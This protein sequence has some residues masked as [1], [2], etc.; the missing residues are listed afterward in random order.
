MSLLYHEVR[1]EPFAQAPHFREDFF[2]CRTARRDEL[3]ELTGALLCADGP[4]TTPVESTLLAE[5]R[6]GH[7]ARYDALNRGRL[8]T[9]R[10]RRN[11]CRA[12]PAQGRPRP[13]RPGRGRGNWL[14]PDAP[15]SADRLFCH[16]CGRGRDQH[17][18][19]PGRPRLL[20]SI[21]RTARP[22]RGQR[23]VTAVVRTPGWTTHPDNGRAVRPR[24]IAGRARR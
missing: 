3:R 24:P 12:A 21:T 17:L 10:L 18:M 2:A 9:G 7:G 14:R 16:T 1:S 19:I 8:D 11:A 22:R 5:H 15:T 13:A 4:V 23:T 20:Q 6:R